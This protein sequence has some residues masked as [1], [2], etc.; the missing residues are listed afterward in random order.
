MAYIFVE[1]FEFIFNLTKN[2]YRKLCLLIWIYMSLYFT[3]SFLLFKKREY[4]VGHALF[5]LDFTAIP[6]VLLLLFILTYKK[7]NNKKILILFLILLSISTSM[8]A[9][10][11]KAAFSEILVKTNTLQALINNKRLRELSLLTEKTM[12]RVDNY[13]VRS[14]NFS[15]IYGY[16]SSSIYYSIENKYLSK[17]NLDMNNSKSVPITNMNSLDS[18]T[19]L[20]N[21]LSVKYFLG[22]KKVPFGFEKNTKKGIYINKNH[23]PFGYTYDTFIEY[24]KVKNISSLD[25]QDL[26]M[27]TCIIDTKS[28]NYDKCVD[29][30][31]S[32]KVKNV[33]KTSKSTNLHKHEKNINTT[34]NKTKK[35]KYTGD[36]KNELQKIKKYEKHLIKYNSDNKPYIDY[37]CN[38]KGRVK[39]DKENKIIFDLNTKND[40]E[41]YLKLPDQNSIKNANK[42]NILT[43]NY[44]FRTLLT[45]KNSRWY[46]GEK[47]IIINLGYFEKGNHKIKLNIP[48][49]AIIDI[50]DMT[51]ELR[52]VDHI[53]ESS[54]KLSKEHLKNLS[55]GSDNLSGNIFVNDSKLLFLS[56]PYS[57]S[58]SAKIDG[59]NTKIYRANIGFMALLVPA[60]NHF[61]CLK[62]ERPCKNLGIILSLTTLLIIL[63]YELYLMIDKSKIKP[64]KH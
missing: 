12:D 45:K 59:K 64:G 57:K 46:A 37:S 63:I 17:F 41:I 38:H 42:I 14:M 11:E 4:P 23:I 19:T 25:K 34:K 26:M 35:F 21:I 52:E 7:I 47:E 18:R 36:S 48:N 53:S 30:S 15:D 62:Y 22:G 24:D 58:W 56:I 31:K 39:I 55:I 29:I 10:I 43:E 61:I 8:I 44:E 54:K 6:F 1:K 60:G 49:G 33:K 2:T 40:G 28:I 16:K 5:A 50:S 27:N 32:K 20:N 9:Y 13:D 51:F 3:Y